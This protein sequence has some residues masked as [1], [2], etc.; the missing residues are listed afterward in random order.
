M[1]AATL[2]LNLIGSLSAL[3]AD[4]DPTKWDTVLTAAKG[5]TVSFNAWGGEP[6]I[7]DYIAWAGAEVEQRFGVKVNQVK[8]ADTAE[9]VQRVLADKTVGNVTGG[10]IDLIWINGQNFAAMKANGLLFGPWA[11]ATPNYSLTE[12]ERNKDI[13]ADFTVPVDGLESPWGRAQVVFYHDFETVTVP[14]KT[15][16]SLLA[17]C[18]ANPGR[19]AYPQPPDFL[20]LTFLKQAL[21]ELVPDRGPLYT[22]VEGQDFEMVTK[23]LWDFLDRLHPVLWRQGRAFPAN[24]TE[25]RRL[26]ADQETKIGFTFNPGDASAAIANREFPPTVESYVLDGGTIGNVHF[27]A[28]PFNAAN[29]EGAMVLAN[30]LLSPLAQAR[31]LD[32]SVWGD[33]TVLSVGTL[34]AADQALFDTLDLGHATLRPQALGTP[35]PEPHPSWMTAIEAAWLKRY[36]AP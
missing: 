24:S 3:A 27:L 14:P 28:I 34:P 31:K 7:N 23:P 30:F 9:A 5:Q 1:A 33:Q 16:S 11:N 17:W 35:I 36:S 32:P 26:F 18:G 22:P 2:L 20:G 21:L 19:F 4:P 12:P 25:L 8:L 6:R 29:K 13:T 15:M 10:A